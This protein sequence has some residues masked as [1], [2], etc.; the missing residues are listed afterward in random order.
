[1]NV[2]FKEK[3]PPKSFFFLLHQSEAPENYA[4]ISHGFKLCRAHGEMS[5]EAS[6]GF[7]DN[8]PKGFIH[9]LRTRNKSFCWKFGY[10]LYFCLYVGSQN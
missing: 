8:V 5:L 10:Q 2:C 3:V 6:A 9:P 7:R 4:C 1:M